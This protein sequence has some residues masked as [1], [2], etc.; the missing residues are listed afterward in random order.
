MDYLDTTFDPPQWIKVQHHEISDWICNGNL[1]TER[2]NRLSPEAFA[3][4]VIELTLIGMDH[5]EAGIC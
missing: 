1:D 4:V 3:T 5:K 2:F